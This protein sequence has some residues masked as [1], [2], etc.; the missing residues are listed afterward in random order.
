M[1]DLGG[2][3][4][5]ELFRGEVEGQM[6][7]FTTALLA[8]EEQGNSAALLAQAMRAAH[9]IKGAAR[10]VQLDA[11]VRLAHVM[12]DCLV[13]AQ[14]GGL[15]LV[16]STIDVLLSAADTLATLSAVEEA[17]VA[18]WLSE[19]KPT[20]DGLLN[21]LAAVR[22]GT[23]IG[24]APAVPVLTVSPPPSAV[25]DKADGATIVPSAVVPAA[26][27]AAAP[28]AAPVPT[29]EARP[30]ADG[31]EDTQARSLRVGAE[32]LN[33]L[34]SMA[35]DNVVQSRW[36]ES[37]AS[38]LRAVKVRQLRLMD[39]LEDLRGVLSTRS[40]DAMTLVDQART[41]LGASVTEVA[42]QQTLLDGASLRA[43]ELAER[44]YRETV[45]T[46][47][48]PFSEGVE[49]FPRLVRD[50]AREL[51]KQAKIEIT[52]RNTPV[53]RDILAKLEA[54]LN[55]M[56][57]N[58]LDHGMEMPDERRASGK[59]PGG[60]LRLDARH[61][62]GRLVVSV[63]DDGRGVDI[64]KLRAKVLDRQLSPPDVAAHLSA[65][66]LLEFL[67]LPGFSTA[68]KVT[69]ISG[70]GVGLDA[71]QETVRAVGGSVRLTTKLGV[72]T[73]IVMELPL[74]LSV[75]RTLVVEIAGEPF[76]LPLTRVDHVMVV[77]RDAFAVLEGHHLVRLA[78]QNIGVV[79]AHELLGLDAKPQWRDAVPVVVLSD[80]NERHGFAV[81][82]FIGEFDVVVRPLDR[83]L[84]KV[85]SVSACA[86]LEDG[87][88]LVILDV[89][90]LMTALKGE[91]Q[92]GRLRGLGS[93]ASE[94][95][96]RKRVLVVEDSITVR[97]L[98]RSLLRA[99]GYEVDVAVD[100]M[101]GLNA[102]RE[103][104]YDLLVT[105]V[106]M[107]R[108]TGIELVKQIREDARWLDLPVII[109]SYK[110]RE[111]DRLRGLEAGADRYM[112][113]SS[114]Q[115]ASFLDAVGELIGLP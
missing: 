81:D 79:A 31:R 30:V 19:R 75:V 18:A 84:G 88:P 45:A 43:T 73:S 20:I 8:V 41:E 102:L 39:L 42:E 23:F 50:L 3:S 17:A 28:D 109:V 51:G 4:M 54:P 27:A 35:G 77:A 94:G 55:H 59:S 10:I 38:D 48:R 82:R 104:Q 113:K 65:E 11:G 91:L 115:D 85:R 67:F 111:E 105:D 37:F 15:T 14:E 71:V 72:G 93:G 74:T 2:F 101:D 16:P 70:R 99:C 6:G 114:F 25:L 7:A 46:R 1:S 90:D 100:G 69:E 26:P 9:S 40:K 34:L 5:W 92:G 89:D 103:N 78:D 83:R 58:C 87:L 53:D 44:L 108:L 110:D 60:T 12:E 95:A 32:A 107:P 13:A 52:G 24:A 29:K 64:E 62:A 96:G 56:V 57:R 47:M 112:T 80:K 21:D 49:A 97:E 106:D 76:A 66:E 22:S 68:A 61:A 98:E 86:L 63:I 33:R 36:L